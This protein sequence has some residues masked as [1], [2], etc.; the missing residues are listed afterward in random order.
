MKETIESLEA[1]RKALY[2]KL[3]E[4]GDFRREPSRS[5]IG[6]VGERIVSMQNRGIL[7]I[8]PNIC[9]TRR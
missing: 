9:G 5:I 3:E 1:Q 4:L 6:N 2:Q 7:A 8:V